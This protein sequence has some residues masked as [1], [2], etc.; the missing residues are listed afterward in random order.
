MT[1]IPG[2]LLD[3][4][5]V[6]VPDAISPV[7]YEL[8]RAAT[9]ADITARFNAAGIPFNVGE[10][11]GDPIV[12]TEEARAYREMLVLQRINDAIRAV[13]LPSSIGADLEN[14]STDFNLTRLVKT[15]ATLT[16]P[17][18]YETDAEFR[19]RR[20]M[21]PEGYAAAGPS[22]AYEFF[23]MSADGSIKQAKASKGV[24]NRVDLVLL[25]R[26]GN[27]EVSPEVIA[28]VHGAISPLTLRPMTD[29]LYTR[30]ADILE[31]EI[32][33]RLT[34]PLGPDTSTV[35]AKALT[36]IQAYANA[37]HS[38]GAPLYL[39]G[40]IGAAREAKPIETVEVLTPVAD[41]DPG[42]FGAVFVTDITVEIA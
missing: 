11:E 25:S 5:V 7:D 40:I 41:I 33:V 34:L 35:Q 37:R 18:V 23:A 26:N 24:D 6:P 1:R 2:A 4:S 8:I 10:V 9:L 15:P 3:M 21:A 13:L 39:D 27:G 20:Q 31:T 17:A 38:I 42:D 12:V 28:I 30:S 22:G 29:A 16:T 32:S 36:A 19:A 14:L